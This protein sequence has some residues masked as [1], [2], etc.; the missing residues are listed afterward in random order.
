M[1]VLRAKV[2]ERENMMLEGNRTGTLAL[3]A[4]QLS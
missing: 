1:E 2:A 3:L 4:I